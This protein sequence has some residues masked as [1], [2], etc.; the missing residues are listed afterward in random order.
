MTRRYSLN[1]EFVDHIPDALTDGVLYVSILFATAV[2]RCCCGCGNEVV[3]PLDP[4][5]WRLTF[6]GNSVSLCP[7]VGNW[8]FDCQSHYWI[9]HNQ[10]MWARRWSREKIAEG[11]A[12]DRF[13]KAQQFGVAPSPV[14]RKSFW[15]FLPKWLRR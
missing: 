13:K 4:T 9:R 15:R 7:S 3:T 8:S 1:H 10:V 5:D 11:R 12:R 14:P 2:H 6:D